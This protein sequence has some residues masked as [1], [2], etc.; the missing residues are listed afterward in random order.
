MATTNSAYATGAGKDEAEL[1]RRN[2][3]SYENA[4]GQHGY[5]VEAEDTKKL[6]KVRHRIP[7]KAIRNLTASLAPGRHPE[8]PR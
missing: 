7:L 8:P 5:K 3:A 4:N 1:R 6:Q 2:V